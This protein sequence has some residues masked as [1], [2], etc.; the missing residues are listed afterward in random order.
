MKKM[1]IIMVL[2]LS[3][4]AF[5]FYT[6]A[7]EKEPINVYLFKSSTCPHCADALEFFEE[8]QTD[9][10]YQ[11]YF[12]LVALETNGNS[13]EIQANVDLAKKVSTYF[14][15]VFE[16]VPVIVIGEKHYVG[17]SSSMNEDL[18]N[19]IIT[20]YHNDTQDVVEGI[21][22]GTLKS[23]NLGAIMTLIVV[24]VV[25]GLFGYFIYLGRKSTE[26]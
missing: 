25:G 26:I 8:L 13:E 22:N 10:E 17:Y 18:K 3:F 1:K 21:K 20:T 5:P 16:G 11:S 19:D 12:R 15:E 24:L 9:S 6:F 23:S 14:G 7:E 4:F 2:L